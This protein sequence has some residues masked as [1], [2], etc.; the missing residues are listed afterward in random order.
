MSNHSKDDKVVFT[1][2]TGGFARLVGMYPKVG[3]RRGSCCPHPGKCSGFYIVSC[4]SGRGGDIIRQSLLVWAYVLGLLS[5][6]FAA[7]VPSIFPF[8]N[9]RSFCQMYSVS[10]TTQTNDLLSRLAHAVIKTSMALHV[11]AKSCGHILVSLPRFSSLPPQSFFCPLPHPQ[12]LVGRSLLKFVYRGD[13]QEVRG[14]VL[15][16]IRCGGIRK[17]SV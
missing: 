16:L 5:T 3:R 12:E 13:R 11:G 17:A 14:S 10:C 1:L 6:V 8:L 4:C 9:V 7:C 15:A 2:A